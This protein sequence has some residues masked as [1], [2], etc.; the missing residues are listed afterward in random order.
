MAD[1]HLHDLSK[2]RIDRSAKPETRNSAGG[3]TMA[4]VLGV[5]AIVVIAA[6]FFFFRSAVSSVTEVDTHTI[7]TISPAQANAVLTASGYVVAQRQAAVASKGTGRLVY[8]GVEEGDQ[9]TDQQIL[10]RLEDN[11]VRA[12]LA[13]ARAALNYERANLNNAQAE[14]VEATANYERMKKLIAEQMVRQADFETAEARF[15]RATAVVEAAEA[16]IGV[17]QAAV[18]AAEIVL[19]NTN[20]RAPFA[21]TV[22]TKNADVGEIVAP[23]GASSTARA[24]VVTIA[25]MSS[26]EVEADVSESNIERIKP[27]QPCE[28]VLDAYQETRYP[29][30]VSKIVP[31][32][33]RA[34]AT[35]LTKI[36]FI[37]RDERVLPEMSAKVTFLNSEASTVM[38]TGTKKIVVP[39]SAVVTRGETKAVFVLREGS[40]VETPIETGNFIGSSLEVLR[41]LNAGERVVLNP[42]A[43]MA[44]G[45]KVKQRVK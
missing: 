11:D 44:T 20:I 12:A 3:R 5:A 4:W 1:S 38:T 23:F 29:G 27:G 33:D 9:V 25:D 43:D 45:A 37:E 10:A 18:N 34:K 17:A 28:I 7:T 30:V 15:K 40:V 41:G 24:A 22:L 26:L 2:L 35:V 14:R 32:A 16:S 19:E 39:P 6:L 13:Q 42:P 31:T 8:L 36:K 21:G